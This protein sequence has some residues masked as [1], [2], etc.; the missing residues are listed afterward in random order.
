MSILEKPIFMNFVEVVPIFVGI[1]LIINCKY[2]RK[3][4]R[5]ISQYFICIYY[6][7]LPHFTNFILKIIL[8]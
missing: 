4:V 6:K 8:K 1:D 3:N 5:T 7:S 2:L